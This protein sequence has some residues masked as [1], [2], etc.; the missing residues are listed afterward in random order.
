MSCDDVESNR[1]LCVAYRKYLSHTLLMRAGFAY[2]CY[3]R[4]GAVPGQRAPHILEM[5]MHFMCIYTPGVRTCTHCAASNHTC[6]DLLRSRGRGWPSAQQVM[7]SNMY[8]LRI[9]AHLMSTLIWI[10]VR[11]ILVLAS[12]AA[13]LRWYAALE[14][15]AQ[16][17][18]RQSA[19]LTNRM[20][21]M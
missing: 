15:N 9:Q 13:V 7:Y 18:V 2:I 8:F 1:K 19:L 20:S 6:R 17:Y 14:Q 11:S 3:V 12:A 21:L 4:D 5:R 16:T 10:R